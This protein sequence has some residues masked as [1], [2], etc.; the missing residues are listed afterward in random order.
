MLVY[1]MFSM[2]LD[3]HQQATARAGNIC[4]FVVVVV[5]GVQ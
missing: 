4:H 5:V 1:D 2:L 3:V